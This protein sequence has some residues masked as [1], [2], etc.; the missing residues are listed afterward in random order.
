MPISFDRAAESYD[1]TRGYPP[2]I[3]ERIGK[4]LMHAAGATPRSRILELGI[5]TG[6]IA[7]PIIRAG[8]SYTGIDISPRMM[9][10]LRAT[11][12]TIPD[13]SQYV[14]LIEG[15]ITCMPFADR[16]FDIVL[17]VHVYHL[18]ADR[19]Q[20]VKEGVRVLARPGVALNG[21]DDAI[22]DPSAEL[23]DAWIEILHRL[24]WPAP[25]RHER[26]ASHLIS[27]EWRRLGGE[28]DQVVDVEGESQWIPASHIEGL[29]KRLWSSTWSVPDDIYPEAVEQIRRWATRHYG[30]MLHTP[31]PCRYRLLIERARF[32]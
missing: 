20:A 17:S 23:T 1:Q 18:I 29:A 8:H 14:Q 30:G 9:E 15:D 3:Q 6:R 32:S 12:L 16:S 28:V 13:A 21:L 24:G 4:A 22:E 27:E 5:G 19:A 25:S 26:K 2:G 10:R 31:L 11:L 7:L